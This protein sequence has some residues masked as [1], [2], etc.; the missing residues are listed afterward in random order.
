MGAVSQ[1]T[2]VS[3]FHSGLRP[4]LISSAGHWH[5]H[6]LRLRATT[7]VQGAGLAHALFVTPEIPI[8]WLTPWR[9][10]GGHWVLRSWCVRWLDERF[11]RLTT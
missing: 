2:L 5:V 10:A 3:L 6:R 11:Y 4:A 7:S 1:V 8:R 9:I